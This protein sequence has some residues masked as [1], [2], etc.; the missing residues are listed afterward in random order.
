MQNQFFK[1]ILTLKVNIS[2][3]I[4]EKNV[5]IIFLKKFDTKYNN[6]Q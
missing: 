5:Y 2:E 1:D 3:I 4:Y 6:I